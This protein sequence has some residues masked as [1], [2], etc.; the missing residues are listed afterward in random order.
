M[1]PVRTSSARKVINEAMRQLVAQYP[2]ELRR[3]RTHALDGDAQFAVI[4]GRR[5]RGR[6]GYV[7]ERLVS[8]ENDGNAVT[9][10]DAELVGKI[11]VVRFQGRLNFAAQLVRSALPLVSQREVTTLVLCVVGLNGEFPFRFRDV[12]LERSIGV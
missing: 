6:L 7:K 9:G 3:D 8:V 11:V 5:P 1:Q 4:Q 2:R 10:S 12:V